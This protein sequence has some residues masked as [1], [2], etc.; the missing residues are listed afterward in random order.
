MLAH[1]GYRLKCDRQSPC[2]SCSKRE[3]EASCTYS[4]N[5][6]LGHDSRKCNNKDSEAQF[7]LQK[8]EK[9]VSSLI[10]KNEE[11]SESC[12]NNTSRHNGTS[13]SNFDDASSDSSPQSSEP[14]SRR[15][16]NLNVPEKGYVN[17][18]HWTA[19]LDNVGGPPRWEVFFPS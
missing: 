10:Q 4:N 16:L 2:V 11:G 6:K 15:T 12:S 8:L 14:S 13:G 9:M 3:D 17:A 19:I 1:G 18:T 5:E 7:R